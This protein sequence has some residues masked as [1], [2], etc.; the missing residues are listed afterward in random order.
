MSFHFANLDD[1]LVESLQGLNDE[2]D[3]LHFVDVCRLSMV[4][5]PE[6]LL[7]CILP[8]VWEVSSKDPHEN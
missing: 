3:D 5:K 1:L 2:L 7:K 8:M 6:K 4:E